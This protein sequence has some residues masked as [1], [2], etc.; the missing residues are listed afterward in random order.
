MIET[1]KKLLNKRNEIL[2]KHLEEE[3]DPF[4]KIAA[5][6]IIDHNI[7]F[8]DKVLYKKNGDEFIK[9]NTIGENFTDIIKSLLSYDFDKE[10]L[11]FR[12][13]LA[14]E[15]KSLLI[16]EEISP[17]LELPKNY[18]LFNNGYFDLNKT[19]DFFTY[20]D[21]KDLNL[22]PFQKLQFEYVETGE[23]PREFLLLWNW[24]TQGDESN[25]RFLKELVGGIISGYQLEHIFNFYGREAS[26]KSLFINL[27]QSIIGDDYYIATKISSLNERFG[28]TQLLGKKLLVETDAATGEEIDPVMLKKI[29]GKDSINIEFKG[30]GI[31]SRNIECNII[32]TSNER[33]Q[34]KSEF[35]GLKRRLLIYDFPYSTKDFDP[36]GKTFRP[37]TKKELKKL[38]KY[39]GR[40]ERFD[41]PKIAVF[42]TVCLCAFSQV[43]LN[44]DRFTISNRMMQNLKEIERS[45]NPLINWLAVDFDLGRHFFKDT[46]RGIFFLKGQ[47]FYEKYKDAMKDAGAYC[48][49][50]NKFMDKAKRYYENDC[51]YDVNTSKMINGERCFV[52]DISKHI[53]NK[54]QTQTEEKK[55]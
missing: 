40:I 12:T 28:T 53:F 31:V 37:I 45:S 32:I 27:L 35:E 16:N 36:E 10:N 46:Q 20:V 21:P 24:W 29:T 19:R 44:D 38:T 25:S 33:L 55:S 9:I 7:W 13:T 2:K 30:G 26:G 18:I 47:T 6:Y 1:I 14:T 51:G 52:I 11:K 39:D 22:A 49:G 3:V 15:L 54:N 48:L 4:V 42:V 50:R 34:F 43:L 5:Q 8:I 41:V 23:I 17:T